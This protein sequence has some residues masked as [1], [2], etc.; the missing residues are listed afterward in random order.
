MFGRCYACL[1]LNFSAWR[2]CYEI[3]QAELQRQTDCT[4]HN[5]YSHHEGCH[6]H[7]EIWDLR[8][9]LC[10][11][12]W[13]LKKFNILRCRLSQCHILYSSCLYSHTHKW[14]PILPAVSVHHLIPWQTFTVF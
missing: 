2:F 13:E 11:R 12:F 5:R 6:G 1:Q 10:K 14:I 8:Y 3:W 7:T 4:S 9:V